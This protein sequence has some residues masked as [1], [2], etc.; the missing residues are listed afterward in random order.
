MFL[1]LVPPLALAALALAT[2]AQ[3]GSFG[4]VYDPPVVYLPIV[5]PQVFYYQP[6]IVVEA[7][8]PRRQVRAPRV[9]RL[10]AHPHQPRAV[11][12]CR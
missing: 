3:A 9:C 10:V 2:P 4:P 6:G 5:Q 8:P 7:P 1:R 11:R 12:R